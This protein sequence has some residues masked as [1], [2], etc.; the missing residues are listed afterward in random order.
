MIA[1]QGCQMN[2]GWRSWI[3]PD[4][5]VN[6]AAGRNLPGHIDAIEIGLNAK[7][8][9]VRS[10]RIERAERQ[11]RFGIENAAEFFRY[12][13]RERGDVIFTGIELAAR[14]HEGF[15]T[16]LAHKQHTPRTIAY[17]RSHDS[18]RAHTPPSS[19]PLFFPPPTIQCMRRR[20]RS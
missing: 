9:F 4:R 1:R 7:A 12:F 8:R 16:A 18:D 5:F 14:L 2:V 11:N 20:A 6:L 3:D 17:Q 15:C 10:Y 13:A 19:P